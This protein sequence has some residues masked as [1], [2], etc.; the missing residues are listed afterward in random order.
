MFKTAPIMF[1]TILPCYWDPNWRI[2]C[3]KVVK[4]ERLYSPPGAQIKDRQHGTRHLIIRALYP[5]FTR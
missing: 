5:T 4:S 2:C 1:D 3:Y